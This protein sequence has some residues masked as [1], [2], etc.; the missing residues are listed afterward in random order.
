MNP[1]MTQQLPAVLKQL[2]IADLSGEL[3]VTS[4]IDGSELG[5]VPLDTR[6]GLDAIGQ[7]LDSLTAIHG[8]GFRVRILQR[9]RL[10]AIDG[11]P[12]ANSPLF[13]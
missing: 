12:L 4:P 3:T 6:P 10:A 7:N 1:T 9:G 11:S 5:S 8:K 2:N 13:A